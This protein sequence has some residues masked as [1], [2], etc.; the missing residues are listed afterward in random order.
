MKKTF[1]TL[2]LLLPALAVAP[3]SQAALQAYWDMD[4]STI[5]GKLPANDGAQAGSLSAS[6][7][8]IEIGFSGGIDPLVGGTTDNLIGPLPSTNRALGFYRVGSV[9]D[10]GSFRMEGFDFTGLNNVNVSF[11][12]QSLD[13]FTWD[14]HLEVDY[15]I[16]NGLWQDIGENMT[17]GSG[18]QVATIDFGS[19]LDG[20]SDVDLRIRTVSWLSAFG[21]LDIDN[22]QVN[23]VPEPR[24]Y[25]LAAGAL[26]LACAVLIRRKRA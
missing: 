25:A 13:A 2:A 15:R 14:T 5:N 22:V 17:W 26:V 11:A 23:A 18:W 12:Y 19:F 7:V 8:D 3:F 9:Y 6:I 10:D 20:A 4:S 24:A 21:H 1:R 16:N